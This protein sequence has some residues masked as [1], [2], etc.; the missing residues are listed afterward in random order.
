MRRNIEVNDA[1]PLMRE[2][3]EDVEDAEGD[4]RDGEKI[5]G[6]KLVGVVYQKYAPCLG[7]RLGMSDHV[8]GD[9]C[10]GDI[11]SELEQF[12]MDSR[13]SPDGII[14]AHGADELPNLSSNPRSP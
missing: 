12:A 5:N 2:N 8:L 14:F 4:C 3:E 10:L 9:S 1:A 7:G 6:G 11:D 13:S